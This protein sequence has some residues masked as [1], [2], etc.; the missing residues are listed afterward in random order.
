MFLGGNGAIGQLMKQLPVGT[1]M[2][3]NVQLVS[4]PLFE[5]LMFATYNKENGSVETHRRMA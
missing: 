3:N 5:K 2:G 4:Y 1:Y